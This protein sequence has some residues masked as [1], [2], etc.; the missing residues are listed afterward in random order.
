MHAP[1]SRFAQAFMSNNNRLLLL[2]SAGVLVFLAGV[3]SATGC[4]SDAS[5]PIPAADAATADA[6]GGSCTGDCTCT[7]TICTCAAGGKC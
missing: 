5:P 4:G 2:A 7:G 6:S 3:V 1:T